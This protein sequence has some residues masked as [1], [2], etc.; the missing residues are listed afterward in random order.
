[1][2]TTLDGLLL[3]KKTPSDIAVEVSKQ[4]PKALKDELNGGAFSPVAT[5]HP[6]ALSNPSKEILDPKDR[7]REI[8]KE[9]IRKNVQKMNG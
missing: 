6:K 7:S 3:T 1:M 9:L 8:V 4:F 2:L 5:S